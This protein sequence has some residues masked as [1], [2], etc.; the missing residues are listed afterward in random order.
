[1]RIVNSIEMKE[2]EKIAK[3]KFGLS[4]NII[5][6]TIG[7][8]ASEYI[9]KNYLQKKHF[10]EVVVLVG[11]GNNGADGLAMARH[12]RRY[13][14][15]LRA[16]LLF[17]END[18]T[19]ELK[20]QL[21]MAKG[22]GVKVTDLQGYEQFDAYFSQMSGSLL[23]IDAIFGTGI[24][25][26]LSQAIFDLIKLVNKYRDVTISI[27]MPSGVCS[28]TGDA[29]GSAIIATETLA[30]A[31]PKVGSYISQGPTHVGKLT[32]IDGGF[33][34]EL[35]GKGH[36]SLLTPSFVS[37]LAQKRDPFAYKNIFGH[38]LTIGGSPGLTGALVLS[39]HA[40]LRVGAG[41]VT[42]L[43]WSESYA[44]FCSSVMPEVMKGVIPHDEQMLNQQMKKLLDYDAVVCGPGMGRGEKG[45]K[46]REIVERVLNFYQGPLVIDAD[47]INVL[48][49][50]K[51]MT[52]LRERRG[53]TVLT[54][55]IGEFS[56]LIGKD[57]K[58]ILARPLEFAKEF[59]EQ[60]NCGLVLKG[61]C[62]LVLFPTNEKFF[63]Y[64]PNPGMATGGTGDVLAGII[65][66]LL[67]QMKTDP[68]HPAPRTSLRMQE[69]ERFQ[70]STCL[71]V[72]VHS[73]AGDLALKKWGERA[74]VASS[75]IDRLAAA[76]NAIQLTS[77]GNETN[78]LNDY[79][80]ESQHFE[81]F[82]TKNES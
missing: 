78:H 29:G 73:M 8:R 51:D 70:A 24:R 5:V 30:I 50:N 2:L 43:T 54:P 6:E 74:M 23:V 46:T 7:L 63:H 19:P 40:G 53:V 35:L 69:F 66:G 67:A 20:R 58:Q 27:D 55:H 4:E 71:A 26:P 18:C 57:S 79:D 3:E 11:K 52:L 16:F 60:T 1:V 41:L 48:D 14:V 82:E 13:N 36:R 80:Y 17:S 77:K 45:L 32:V 47:A 22:F 10:N 34:N 33:P 76:F 38:L 64:R 61:P 15:S 72:V 12:L 9:Y 68:A 62:T 37:G 56:R 44:E 75:I 59:V 21:S 65:G 28:D 81:F 42:A 39:S 49:L 25:L 31:L